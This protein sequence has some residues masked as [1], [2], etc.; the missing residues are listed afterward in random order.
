MAEENGGAI[1]RNDPPPAPEPVVPTAVERPTVDLD[2]DEEFVTYTVKLGGELFI[3]REA[4]IETQKAIVRAISESETTVAQARAQ[5]QRAARERAEQRKRETAA[6]GED[7]ADAIKTIDDELQAELAEIDQARDDTIADLDAVYTQL[8]Y[9][10]F[11]AE[12]ANEGEPPSR[13]FVD[14]Y[15]R[16]ST[17][18]KLNDKFRAVDAEGKS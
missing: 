11:H 7:D 5:R 15:I 12:G 9:V 6:E 17:L 4:S 13:E 1:V 8:R 3:A 14:R 18:R 16:R 10:L 2:L